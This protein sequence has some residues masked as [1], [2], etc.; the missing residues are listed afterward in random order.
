VAAPDERSV[1]NDFIRAIVAADL[2]AGKNGGRV[3]TRFP[4]NPTATSTS[5]TP[6]R[7]C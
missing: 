2:A 3:I 7:S 5:G 6:S 1:P 4:P